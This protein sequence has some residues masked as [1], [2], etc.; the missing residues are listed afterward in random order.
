MNVRASLAVG[1]AGLGSIG[2]A[3]MALG[4]PAGEALTL[5]GIAGL[6]VLVAGALGAGLLL[7]LRRRPIGVQVTAVVLVSVA[8]VGVGAMAAAQAM[9]LSQHDLNALLVILLAAGTTG[10]LVAMA[11]GHRVSAASRSLERAVRR[12]GGD[13]GAGLGHDAAPSSGQAETGEFAALAH[14]LDDMSRRLEQALA[15]ERAVDSSRRELTAWVSH[16]LRTPLAGIRAIAEA[17]EDGV[18]DDPDIVARYHRTLR[19]ET[20]RLARLVDELFELSVINA[21]A[22]RL[23]TERVNL[24]DLVSDAL[25]AS[26]AGARARGVHLEGRLN[27]PALELELSPSE[28]ARVLRNLLENAVRHTP[29][30]GSVWVE[31]GAEDG[32]V[33]VSVTDECG[34]IPAAHLDRVFDLAFRGEVARTPGVEG[35]AGLG[36]A[37]AKGIVEAHHGDI[38]V[39]NE[40]GGCRFTVRLPL[41]QTAAR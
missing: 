36:L 20:D 8:T 10:A 5:A 34:G 25:A 19:V 15:R 33:Y 26:S 22:L 13:L 9:F 2:A 18:V 21:G 39:R 38:T 40:S 23:Q 14:E 30:D 29:S 3:S 12:I 27:G 28:V 24:G 31:A 1:L 35:G 17:L 32:G 16:D 41:S 37:I 7:T 4:M 11:L 6:A